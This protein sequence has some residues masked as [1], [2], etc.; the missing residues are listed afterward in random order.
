VSD[1]AGEY[2]PLARADPDLTLPLEQRRPGGLGVFL[3]KQL[4]D[5]VSYERREGRNHLRFLKRFENK[6]AG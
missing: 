5:E 6:V 2:N 3:V 1:S 4:A